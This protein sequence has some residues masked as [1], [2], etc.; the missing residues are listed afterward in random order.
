MQGTITLERQG[1][2]L[3][4]EDTESRLY[5][6]HHTGIPASTNLHTG[7]RIEFDVASNPMK[8]GYVMAVNVVRIY[9][10]LRGP[11]QAVNHGR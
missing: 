10:A 2:W 3:C 1:W 4:E 9:R 6:V 8:P 7:D 5:F 11:R